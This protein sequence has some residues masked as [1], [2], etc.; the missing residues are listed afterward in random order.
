MK[1]EI[2][3]PL[4]NASKYLVRCLDSVVSQTF[5]DIECIL[6][7]DCGKDDSVAI[8]KQYIQDYHRV[9]HG[10]CLQCEANHT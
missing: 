3:C 6:V 7:D 10:R 8:A 9:I 1:I 4:Y 2:I 5:Q